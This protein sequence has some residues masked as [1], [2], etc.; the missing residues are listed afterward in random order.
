MEEIRMR[1][2]ITFQRRIHTHK[3]TAPSAAPIAPLIWGACIGAAPAGGPVG[4]GAGDPV[5]VGGLGDVVVGEVVVVADVVVAVVSDVVVVAD[6]IVVVISDVVVVVGV[7]VVVGPPDIY[8]A[9]K[10]G[11]TAVGV[12]WPP[13]SRGTGS[14]DAPPN[15][16]GWTS[17]LGSGRTVVLSGLRTL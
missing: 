17:E 9:G 10:R 5:P 16:T 7:E 12:G 3:R 14:D 4:D 13:V 6:V 8:P 1:R 15:A 11:M 2:V